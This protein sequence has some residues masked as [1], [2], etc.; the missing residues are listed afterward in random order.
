MAK[1]GDIEHVTAA[2]ITSEWV[3]SRQALSD[4]EYDQLDKAI[5]I[6]KKLQNLYNDPNSDHSLIRQFEL[7]GGSE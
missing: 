2:D 6:L 1:T 3:A 5:D 4:A 7:W